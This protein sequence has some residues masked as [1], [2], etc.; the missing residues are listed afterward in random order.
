MKEFETF[1]K[2]LY[3]VVKGYYSEGEPQ[4]YDYPG[5]P[6]NFSICE[7]NLQGVDVSVLMSD[8]DLETIEQQ[9]LDKYY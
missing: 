4:T 1:Y 8:Y 7:V 9:I 6:D 5:S 3:L 2:D